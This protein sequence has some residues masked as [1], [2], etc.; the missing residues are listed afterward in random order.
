MAGQERKPSL[1]HA[2]YLL[3]SA[4]RPPRL[5]RPQ[6]ASELLLRAGEG[7]NEEARGPCPLNAHSLG[8]RGQ[9][10]KGYKSKTE[11]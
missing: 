8:E 10:G 5:L 3:P 4:S 11:Y 9:E 7:Q 6:P 1:S 2:A